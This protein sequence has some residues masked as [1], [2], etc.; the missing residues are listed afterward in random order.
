MSVKSWNITRT[1]SSPRLIPEWKDLKF[2]INNILKDI[3]VMCMRDMHMVVWTNYLLLPSLLWHEHMCTALEG[4]SHIPK[5]LPILDYD[6]YISYIHSVI[7]IENGLT[8]IK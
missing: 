7:N 5:Q 4:P 2:L 3:K 8:W 1:L 6:D